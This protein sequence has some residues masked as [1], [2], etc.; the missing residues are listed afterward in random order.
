MLGVNRVVM[1]A[2]FLS[3][4]SLSFETAEDIESKSRFLLAPLMEALAEAED[5]DLEA[6]ALLL[7]AAADVE[8]V[9]ALVDVFRSLLL[10]NLFILMREAVIALT[11]FPRRKEL[12]GLGFS[13]IT[14]CSSKQFFHVC[15]FVTRN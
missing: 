4:R 9:A 12:L 8:A 7:P 3:P 14:S 13:E 2:L 15:Y 10:G 11:F 1:A 6:P 5:L